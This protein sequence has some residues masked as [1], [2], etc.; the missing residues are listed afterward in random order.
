MDSSSFYVGDRKVGETRRDW[1]RLEEDKARQGEAEGDEGRLEGP[2]TRCFSGRALSK[3]SK[4]PGLPS[5]A[6]LKRG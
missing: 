6:M 2:P 4:G 1:R 5:C 3:V